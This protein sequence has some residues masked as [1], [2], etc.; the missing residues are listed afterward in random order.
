M[1]PRILIV[2]DDRPASQALL[3]LFRRHGCE[4]VETRTAE[5]ALPLLE[6]QK[7]DAILLD[8]KLA[9]EMDGYA[10]LESLKRHSV[11]SR[12]P[13]LI[14]TNFGMPQEI[15]KGRATGAK[16]Y[17]VKSDRSVHEIVDRALSYVQKPHLEDVPH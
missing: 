4:V 1:K 5:E 11:A 8:L 13:V 10:F 9:G 15:E 2:E 3:H 7:P 12:I 6:K 16:D 17:L 14:I